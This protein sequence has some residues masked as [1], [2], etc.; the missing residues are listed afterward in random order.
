MLVVQ[1]VGNQISLGPV[2]LSAWF[3]AA[4]QLVGHPLRELD[5]TCLCLPPPCP[6]VPCAFSARQ[7]WEVLA[8][9]MAEEVDEEQEEET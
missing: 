8:V 2:R 1:D 9:V 5:E 4:L 7:R 3:S 6:S